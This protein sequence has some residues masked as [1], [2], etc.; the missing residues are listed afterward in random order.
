[1]NIHL[2]N[3]IGFYLGDGC[4]NFSWDKSVQLTLYCNEEEYQELGVLI[5]RA[6]FNPNLR[7]RLNGERCYR[8]GAKFR[9]ILK[10][11]IDLREKSWNKKL[12]DWERW[13]EG[14][15]WS[16]LT[17]LINSDGN[18]GK[19][20]K[21]NGKRNTG[22]TVTFKTTSP[23]LGRGV[24]EIADYLGLKTT[25]RRYE[26]GREGWRPT[27]LLRFS[28]R[29]LKILEENLNLWRNKQSLL[30]ELVK[31]PHFE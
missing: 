30:E 14:A 29:N 28:R 8:P 16:L 1:M 5:K 26:S 21:A 19:S 13:S 25:F 6:G 22:A 24:R 3:L 23:G 18:V 4:T 12:P 9:D 27:Y 31:E 11:Y 7:T 17:G 20:Q 10:E 2:A 15:L